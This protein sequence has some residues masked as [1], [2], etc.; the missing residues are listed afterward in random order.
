MRDKNLPAGESLVGVRPIF[1]DIFQSRGEYTTGLFYAGRRRY[2]HDEI[3]S[4]GPRAATAPVGVPSALQPPTEFMTI[5][6]R[7]DFLRLERGGTHSGF[8]RLE[9]KKLAEMEDRPGRGP[10]G[11]GVVQNQSKTITIQKYPSVDPKDWREEYQAGCTFYVHKGTGE[12]CSEKPWEDL[13]RRRNT[14]V[15]NE[16]VNGE[17]KEVGLA[18]QQFMG[19]GSLV[20]DDSELNDLFKQLDAQK[21]S[22]RTSTIENT[23]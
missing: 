1:N 8:Q 2:I 4:S 18:D 20:Y 15:R 16:T 11:K 9:F 7:R 10:L 19:T 23:S 12:A 3:T 17:S 13:K 5:R 22:N 14:V 6:Q 21:I